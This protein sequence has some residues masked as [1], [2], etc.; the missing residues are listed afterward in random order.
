[1]GANLQKSLG[2]ENFSIHVLATITLFIISF[3]F[4]F[5]I[6]SYFEIDIFP[7][8]NRSTIF[9]TF[10]AYIFD[11]FT[12]SII[13]TLLTTLWIGLSLG[14]K[15][16]I[17][18]AIVY[19]S[20]SASAIFTNFSPLLDASVLVSIPLIA[21]FFVYHFTTKKIIQI[22][23]KLLFSYFSLTVLYIAI[24]GFII[25]LFSLSSSSGLPGWI[26][27]HAVDIFLV[28]SSFSPAFIIFF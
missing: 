6:S 4:I 8:E 16:R 13:I 24:S 22:H 12:D 17:A 18:S 10:H 15:L 28:F 25:I 20:L 3:F 21:S 26:R 2:R 14:G 9:T 27:N 7:L 23:L 19:G 5:W 11:E 1:L